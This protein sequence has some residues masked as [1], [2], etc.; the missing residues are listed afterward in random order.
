M[1]GRGREPLVFKLRRMGREPILRPVPD[2]PWKAA[3]V[4][5]CAAIYSDGLFHV[6]YRATD[7]PFCLGLERPVEEHKYTSSIGYAV[8][9]DGIHFK[10]Y[11]APILVGETSQEMWGVEDPRITLLDGRYYMIYTASG[12]RDWFDVRPTIIGSPDLV[13][14][15]GRRILLDEMIF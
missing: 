10:R 9:T 12:G 7:K 5:N 6:W 8:S 15:E 1:I 3:A 11:N 14:C 13:R 4:F 2:H